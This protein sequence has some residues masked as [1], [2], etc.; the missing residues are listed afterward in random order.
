MQLELIT[1]KASMTTDKS[2]T[3]K[4]TTG[5]SVTGKPAT[6]KPALI[7]VH[8]AWHGAWCWANFLPYFSDKGYDCFAL[9]LRGHGKSEGRSSLRWSRIA[10]YV[11][12]LRQLVSGLDREVVIVG[13]S[14]GG[15]VTQ[16][17]LETY[18]ARG[19]VLL[20]T[21]PTC[22]A[23]GSVFRTFKNSPWTM[24]KV[25]FTLSL[26][27]LVDSPEKAR[28]AF[29]S[30]DLPQEKLMKYYR[31]LQDESYFALL[32]MLFSALPKPEK[33]STPL[34]I[35]GAQKDTIFTVSEIEATARAYKTEAEFMP[36]MAHDMML[37]ENWQQAAKRIRKWMDSLLG[38][39]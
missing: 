8:G 36:N 33:I 15:L 26:Y 25:M 20:A 22:G 6:D 3:S 10:D 7:F 23:L 28:F 30:E 39:G 13:H 9:S 17:Y 31:N 5:K 24:L 38:N 29:F 18:P 32:G 14:M 35:L 11:A 19:A 12:D 2:A 21:V 34:F 37:E 27:P 1:H 4:S 16:K